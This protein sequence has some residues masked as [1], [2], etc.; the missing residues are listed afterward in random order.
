V[1]VREP[2]RPKSRKSAD[3]SGSNLIAINK[4]SE[5]TPGQ[6]AKMAHGMSQTI[7]KKAEILPFQYFS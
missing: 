4:K 6:L 3:V 7:G 2:S 1:P 5:Q